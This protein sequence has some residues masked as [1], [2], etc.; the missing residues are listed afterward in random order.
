MPFEELGD[1][2]CPASIG[3]TVDLKFYGRQDGRVLGEATTTSFCD[4]VAFE[5]RGRA[6]PTLIGATG[7]IKNLNSLLQMRL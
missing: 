6:E 2:P 7:L 5:V 1:V 3:P 4:S